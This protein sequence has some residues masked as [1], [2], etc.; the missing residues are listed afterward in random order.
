MF[1]IKKRVFGSTKETLVDNYNVKV[2]SKGD[3]VIF[4]PKYSDR[5]VDLVLDE[6]KYEIDSKMTFSM[7][8]LESQSGVVLNNDDVLHRFSN[9]VS[10]ESLHIMLSDNQIKDLSSVSLNK[11][12][13][14]LKQDTEHKINI[15]DFGEDAIISV[16]GLYE[17][18]PMRLSL[19]FNDCFPSV[20]IRDIEPVTQYFELSQMKERKIRFKSER[21]ISGKVR[22][23]MKTIDFSTDEI[24]N[25]RDESSIY[26][27]ATKVD[28]KIDQWNS[29]DYEFEVRPDNYGP[30]EKT[31]D[32]VLDNTMIVD[33]KESELHQLSEIRVKYPDWVVGIN[34]HI[35][36]DGLDASSKYKK[37][38]KVGQNEYIFKNIIPDEDINLYHGGGVGRF[39]R[40]ILNISGLK[41]SQ[42]E[43]IRISLTPKR[44]GVV[45]NS[46]RNDGLNFIMED[47]S[48]HIGGG[49]SEYV[50]FDMKEETEIKVK[51]FDNELIDQINI[52]KKDLQTLREIVVADK[53]VFLE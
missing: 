41:E 42:C 45:L 23:G 17:N 47:K 22:F 52:E 14:I 6:G 11:G 16:S 20:T 49:E 5:N 46:K 28:E 39:E 8:Y 27:K 36:Y 33:I 12:S 3:E 15:W 25:L 32:K 7:E 34:P 35:N 10:N 30:I 51:S 9:D 53:S 43:F 1:G 50:E 18:T 37:T 38:E 26:C 29:T 44:K 13:N 31:V 48:V 24:Y 21:V 4:R 2:V 19:E 40:N